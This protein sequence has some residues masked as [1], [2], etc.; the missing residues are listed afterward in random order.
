MLVKINI[1]IRRNRLTVSPDVNTKTL[2]LLQNMMEQHA[3]R[4]MMVLFVPNYFSLPPSNSDYI[5][6][7]PAE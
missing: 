6:E 3:N 7:A 2:S 5:M 1:I 4:F